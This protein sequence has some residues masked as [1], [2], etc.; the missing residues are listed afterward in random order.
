M[1]PFVSIIIPVYNSAEY[2]SDAIQ[3][4]LDQTYKNIEIIIVDD[5]STDR[6]WEIIESYKWKYPNI[7]KSFKQENK[8]AC[9]ARNKGAILSNGQI[10]QFLDS[11][12]ILIQN[13]IEEQII[14]LDKII[15]GEVLF[16]N[17]LNFQGK[18]LNNISKSDDYNINGYLL[19]NDAI[20]K[21]LVLTP[22]ILIKKEVFINNGMF[23]ENLIRA[24]EHEFNVRLMSRGIK[25]YYTP[26]YGILVRHHD[27]SIRV[28]N[29]NILN[30]PLYELELGKIF[31]NYIVKYDEVNS[32]YN[33]LKNELVNYLIS[34]A[35][36]YGNYKRF[37]IVS[38][39]W[40]FIVNFMEENDLKYIKDYKSKVYSILLNI[41][42][43]LIF[44]KLRIKYQFIRKLYKKVF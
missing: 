36:W 3:S 41:F 16:C 10:L 13:K 8:G 29:Q 44:E 40:K 14:Y 25:Y 9:S 38:I 2:V 20:Y 35:Q 31:N 15:D 24:Q 11:D 26:F 21:K 1:N 30:N 4:A 33:C 42:G 19:L 32:S 17:T 27:S 6:S 22:C 18:N 5:G 43:L 23:K 7:I 37:D 12:D 39:Y 34:R 28:S